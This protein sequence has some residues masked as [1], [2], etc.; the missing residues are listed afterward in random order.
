MRIFYLLIIM[1]TALSG[2]AQTITSD[3]FPSEGDF[4]TTVHANNANEL[5]PGEAGLQQVWDFSAATTNY[6]PGTMSIYQSPNNLVYTNEFHDANLALVNGVYERYYQIEGDQWWIIGSQSTFSSSTLDA[7]YLEFQTPLEFGAS[8]SD[9]FHRETILISTNSSDTIIEHITH[10]NT[11]DG[12]G[13]LITPDGTIENCYRIKTERTSNPDGLYPSTSL[14][15]S[16]YAQTLGIKRARMTASSNGEVG[17]FS[18]AKEV[19]FTTPVKEPASNN[20]RLAYLGNGSLLVTTD[21][22][23]SVQLALYNTAGQLVLNPG[24]EDLLSGANHLNLALSGLPASMYFLI[25]SD[26]LSR[27]LAQLKIVKP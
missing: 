26:H 12:V 19:A 22:P 2:T 9:E 20:T 21:S 8:F 23:Q 25:V 7:P 16:W 3:W 27:P 10:T 1:N 6:P 14:H 5:N 17:N 11:F 4:Y 15:Y 18:W 24:K 13:T